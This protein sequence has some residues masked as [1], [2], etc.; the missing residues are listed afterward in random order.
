MLPKIVQDGMIYERL[1]H[2][3]V[4]LKDQKYPTP[5]TLHRWDARVRINLNDNDTFD[6][7]QPNHP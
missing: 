6:V 7:P 1:N 5:T 4:A 2:I 3:L